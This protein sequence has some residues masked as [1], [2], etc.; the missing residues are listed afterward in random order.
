MIAE[1][2]DKYNSLFDE[3][4]YSEFIK[5]INLETNNRLDF[6]ISETPLFLNESLCNKLIQAG[7]EILSQIKT[8]EFLTKS[9]NHVILSSYEHP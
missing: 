9:K 3:N 4:N 8:N 7:D 6:R 1:I 5:N 2:R